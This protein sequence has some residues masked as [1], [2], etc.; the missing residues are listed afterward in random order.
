MTSCALTLKLWRKRL[1]PATA[2]V[3]GTDFVFYWQNTN[4]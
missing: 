1:N 3:S 4:L 2:G